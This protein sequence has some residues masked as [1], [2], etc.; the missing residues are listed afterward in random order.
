MIRTPC[1]KRRAPKRCA[2]LEADQA[3]LPEILQVVGGEKA[4]LMYD[5]G[6]LGVGVISCGQGVGMANDIPSIEELFDRIIKEAS[7]IAGK[8]AA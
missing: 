2:E 7:E 3:N 8:L 5:Q 6:D 4:R 1:S